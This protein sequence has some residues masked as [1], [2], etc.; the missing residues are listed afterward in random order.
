MKACHALVGGEGNGGVI[1]PKVG[2]GRD[3]LVGMTIALK[4]LAESKKTVSETISS[5]PKYLMFRDKFTVTDQTQVQSF[6]DKMDTLFPNATVNKEDGVKILLDDAWVHA[7]PS[8]T[9]PIIRLFIEAKSSDTI[10][11]LRE[12][13]SES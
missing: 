6:L 12:K 11:S 1:Y 13:I 10:A 7:R 8:N 2:W 5:Y 3:S 9:E 4:H